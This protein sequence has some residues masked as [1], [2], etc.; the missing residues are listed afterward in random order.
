MASNWVG[1]RKWGGW[2]ERMNRREGGGQNEGG[3]RNVLGARSQVAAGRQ[4]D[5]EAVK[6]RSTEGRKVKS[7]EEKTQTKRTRL[8]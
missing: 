2:A 8:S 1:E 3:E 4:P 6:V 7:P 5:T